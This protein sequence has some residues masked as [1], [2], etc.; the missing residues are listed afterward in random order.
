MLTG[1]HFLKKNW[2]TA[3]LVALTM[4][5]TYF[6]HKHFKREYE[7]RLAVLPLLKSA[8][9][10]TPYSLVLSPHS[11]LLSPHSPLL[12]PH[13]SLLTTTSNNLLLLL[14]GRRCCKDDSAGR[15]AAA[16]L[17]AQVRAARAARGGKARALSLLTLGLSRG[18]TACVK[19]APFSCRVTF[20]RAHRWLLY[21]R[22][23]M[24]MLS[25]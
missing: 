14:P 19:R 5:A 17:R 1:I 12:T 8:S 6:A 11:L 18:A 13:S 2:L 21:C 10:V 16:A 24:A 15:R 23:A 20:S 9:K 4:P 25:G 7:P 3:A 22:A